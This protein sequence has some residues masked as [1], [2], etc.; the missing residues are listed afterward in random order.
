MDETPDRTEE[1]R[2]AEHK[3]L[4]KPPKRLAVVDQNSCSGCAGSPACVTYCETVT[5]KEKVVDAIRTVAWPGS[6]FELAVV[7][8]DKCIGCAICVAVCPWDAITM[9]TYEEGL[10]VAPEVTL[11]YHEEPGEVANAAAPSVTE[12]ASGS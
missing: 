7:E 6:P 8:Y 1:R 5:V 2:M 3:F 9:Y 4:A 10:K 12:E 11:V